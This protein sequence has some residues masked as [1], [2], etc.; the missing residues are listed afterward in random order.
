MRVLTLLVLALLQMTA[1]AAELTVTVDRDKLYEDESLVM[2]VHLRDAQAT[3]D[4][5]LDDFDILQR[6]QGSQTQFLNGVRSDSQTWEFVLAPK[7]AGTLTIPAFNLAD[8][9]SEAINLQVSGIDSRAQ[10]AEDRPFFLRVSVSDT[11]PFVQQQIIYTM[12]LYQQTP[13]LD[14]NV[15]EP[16]H[17]DIQ[18][19]RL[20]LD[21]SYLEQVDGREYSVLERQYALF[22]QRSGEITLPA[23]N[24]NAR[25]QVGQRA[26]RFFS[27]DTRGIR[28]RA[29]AIELKVKAAADGYTAPWWLASTEVVGSAK[30]QP[31]TAQVGQPL[32]LELQITAEGVMPA[33][34]PV[35][36]D[37]QISGVRLYSDGSRA[38]KKAGTD[39]VVSQRV[40]R[41]TIIP[42]RPGALQVPTFSLPWW[43]LNS[44][45]Q[46][47]LSIEVPEL[48]VTGEMP[49]GQPAEAQAEPDI[50]LAD[51]S[52]TIDEQQQVGSDG[53]AAP[54][55]VR[56]W[57]TDWRTQLVLISIVAFAALVIRRRRRRPLP[58]Q[59]DEQ[60]CSPDA[61]MVRLVEAVTRA[62]VKAGRDALLDWGSGTFKQ[63]IRS[64][65]H[66][67]ERLDDDEF[68]KL[69][70][71]LD[72][73]C[74][75]DKERW[76]GELL[77]EKLKAY[78]PQQSAVAQR[79]E[80]PQ[81]S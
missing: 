57:F 31:E 46:K 80:L 17:P 62:D 47:T 36:D 67:A 63:E 45:S 65:P 35:I 26:N 52:A 39:G 78:K 50:E 74:Y 42:T 1:Y 20:G 13:I 18:I 51:E 8:A 19:E 49:A 4:P 79:D 25:V 7:R 21:R 22:A 11:E 15:T 61:A 54:S 70:L 73:I 37:P 56:L 33:Q 3:F 28:V 81:L 71:E 68:A 29:Q 59:T 60:L 77:L 69:V 34:L 38:A 41:W 9:Q 16:D 58:L 14:G 5:V 43:D 27:A 66:L 76:Y 40:M 64:L 24:L 75:R 23:I 53:E 12:K 10:G 6:S 2:S 55:K 44:G 30:W 48:H 32:T 72:V